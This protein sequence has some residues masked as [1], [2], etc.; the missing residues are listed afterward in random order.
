MAESNIYDDS[1]KV[2]GTMIE[3]GG[4][5]VKHLGAALECADLVNI[6]RVK[7]AFPEYWEKYLIMT[8]IHGDRTGD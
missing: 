3:Y 7:T 6:R 5:F 8:D 4:C 1:R 2:A